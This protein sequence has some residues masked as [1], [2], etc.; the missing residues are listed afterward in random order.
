MYDPTESHCTSEFGYSPWSLLPAPEPATY[1]PP[2]SY[3]YHNVAKHLIRDTV[4]L[5]SNGLHIDLNRVMELEQ[6]LDQQLSVVE[7]ELAENPYIQRYLHQFHQ[8]EIQAYIADRKSKC[9]PAS[10]YL[11]PFNPKD[12]NHRSY[13][14]HLFAQQQGFSEPTDLLPT[15]I[16]KWTARQVAKVAAQFPLV[17]RVF[18]GTETSHPLL[19][20][21]MDLLAE[22]KADM[23]N[24][25]FLAQIKS[26]SVEFPKFNPGSPKQKQEL[27]EMLNIESDKTS[28]TSGAASF[29]R[30]EIERI[31]REST[32]PHVVH[33]TKCLI[34]HSFAAIVRNNFIEAFYRYTVNGR[35]Y[36]QYKLLGA[37]SGRF[38]SSNPNMLNAPSTGS[39]FAKPIK[40]CFTAPP[41]YLV[42]AIDYSALEDRV[43]ASLSRD[44]NKC[45][46]FLEGLDGHSL[47]ATYY[48]PGRVT[49]IIGQFTDNKEASRL[50]KAEVDAGN[51]AA[52]SVRQDSKPISFGLAYGAF[53]KK[54]AAT[55]KIPLNEAEDIFNAYHNELYPGITEYRENYVLPTC[56]ANGKIHLGLGFYL[57]T[58]DP[59]RDIRTCNNATAQFW[60]ILTA[61]A[62]NELHR[63]IDEAGLAQDIIVTSTIYDSIYLEVRNSPEYIK[64]L[65]DNLVSIMITDFMEDQTVHNEANLEIGLDWADLHEL[66]NNASLDQIQSVL[67]QL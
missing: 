20:A 59:D 38:T 11:K 4:R 25:K 35:L 63:R 52:K 30:D 26:P 8:R 12:T 24:S 32:D 58:D 19:Q 29:D 67:E 17:K 27:F 55:V 49:S 64:W 22:H 15:G 37:K 36:G 44:D 28:K 1:N 9:R 57:H 53:P 39:I 66:P 31:N 62:I 18:D 13:F 14:M 60:S 42:A 56:Q 7:S 33:L 65:N 23:Y 47:S 10:Y 2:A 50:L 51:K 61:L 48:Y 21:A 40:R 6:T 3:F 43:I 54:V 45:G 41:G 5:M 34:D 46:L 16:P